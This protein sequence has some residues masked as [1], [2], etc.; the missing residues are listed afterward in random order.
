MKQDITTLSRIAELSSK[1]AHKSMIKK[2]FVGEAN[3][4]FALGGDKDKAYKLLNDNLSKLSDQKSLKVT[5]H[6]AHWLELNHL[7]GEVLS[8]KK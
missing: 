8:R 6:L 5:R 3:R 7:K 1:M 2:G 4:F